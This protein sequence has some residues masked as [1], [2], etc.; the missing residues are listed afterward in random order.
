MNKPQGRDGMVEPRQ[1]LAIRLREGFD[2]PHHAQVYL[3]GNTACPEV[4]IRCEVHI[5]LVPGSFDESSRAVSVVMQIKLTAQHASMA[6]YFRVVGLAENLESQLATWLP[7][8]DALLENTLFAE[9][10]AA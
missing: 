10:A 9:N 4:V 7:Q 3:A 6:E 1:H 5:Q 2:V 8:R